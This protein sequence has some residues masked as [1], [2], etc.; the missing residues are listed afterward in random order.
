MAG[1]AI[2]LKQLKFV[3]QKWSHSSS[4]TS[5]VP[6][7][8]HDNPDGKRFEK[9][10]CYQVRRTQTGLE[11]LESAGDCAAEHASRMFGRRGKV[12]SAYETTK[13]P[14]LL[15]DSGAEHLSRWMQPRQSGKYGGV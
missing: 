13:E 12:K 7:Y 10:T 6:P 3:P 1:K 2:Y 4:T 14:R 11:I 8:Y 9:F 15:E 5:D